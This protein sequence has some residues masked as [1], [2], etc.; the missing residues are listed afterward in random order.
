MRAG[1]KLPVGVQ[2]VGEVALQAVAFCVG[3]WC[4]LTLFSAK[5]CDRVKGMLLIL[6]CSACIVLALPCQDNSL[7]QPHMYMVPFPPDS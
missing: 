6:F 3:P 5:L 2:I 4:K 7:S 1:F